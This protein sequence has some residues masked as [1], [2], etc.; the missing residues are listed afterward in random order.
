MLHHLCWADDLYAMAGAMDHLTRILGDM[1]NA[2]EQFG[3][4][5]K[6]KSLTIVA[7][8]YTKHK[9]GDVVETIS[10]KS[11][12][13]GLAR[14]GHGGAGPSGWTLVAAQRPV[15]GTE[16]PKV[17]PCSLRRKP[18]SVIPNFLLRSV[19]M[20]FIRRVLLRCFTV[21]VNWA[22]TQSM[23]QARRILELG[24]LRRVLCACAG[25]QMNVGRI[26]RNE[27]VPLLL[28]R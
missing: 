28:G 18:C 6:G 26:T 1:T 22:Y 14:S 10:S 8:P 21:L 13:W 4:Q 25:D 20:P 3:K 17:T 24:K 19:F 16:S 27:M 2:I 15:C 12:R 23:F 7:G 11:R 5:W 9:A